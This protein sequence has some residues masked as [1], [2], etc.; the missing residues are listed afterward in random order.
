LSSASDKN[1]VK[2]STFKDISAFFENKARTA[3]Q[4]V[5]NR[6]EKRVVRAKR[7]IQL[8]RFACEQSSFGTIPANDDDDHVRSYRTIKRMKTKHRVDIEQRTHAQQHVDGHGKT[9]DDVTSRMQFAF[10]GIDRTRT[11]C[12]TSRLVKRFF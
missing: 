8:D 2:G 4:A 12:R 6:D 1:I 9:N 5:T 11:Q 7:T 3:L 10:I